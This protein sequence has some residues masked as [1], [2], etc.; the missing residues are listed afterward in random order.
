MGDEEKQ[1]AVD[2]FVPGVL[3]SGRRMSRADSKTLHTNHDES[4]PRWSVDSSEPNGDS[5]LVTPGDELEKKTKL[6]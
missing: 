5:H 2:T 1:K 6:L 3:V 4:T